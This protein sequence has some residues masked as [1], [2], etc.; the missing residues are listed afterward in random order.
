VLDTMIGWWRPGAA[1][2][3]LA[4]AGLGLLVASEMGWTG[5]LPPAPWH[6]WAFLMFAAAALLRCLVPNPWTGSC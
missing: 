1:L 6:R 4:L 5:W 2:V 3:A